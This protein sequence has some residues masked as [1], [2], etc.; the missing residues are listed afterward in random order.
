MNLKNI[1]ALL[2][3]LIVVASFSSEKVSFEGVITYKTDIN[4][5]KE[6]VQYREYYEQ[7]FGDTL[8]VYYSES[9]NILK[10]FINTGEKGYDFNLYLQSENHY[11]AKWKNLDTIYHYNVSE[12]T[13][14]LVQK[15]KGTSIKILERDCNFIQIDGIDP[16]GKQPISQ[17]FYYSGFPYIDSELFKDY[18]DFFTYEFLKETK[19]PF[20][21]MVLDLGDYVITYTAIEVESKK[22]NSKMFNLPDGNPKKEY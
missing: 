22:L 1:F 15:T 3:I 20:M 19:S 18:N 12:Q 10:K 2:V 6:N 8:K 21:K 14:N 4:F 13:L 7:K 9:G 17:K 5:K 16:L 11:Y